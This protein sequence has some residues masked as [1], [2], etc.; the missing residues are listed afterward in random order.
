MPGKVYCFN[1]Y[2]EPMI[3]SVNGM[4]AGTISG[5][6]ASGATIYTPVSVAVDRARHGDHQSKPVFADDT[7]TP[8]VLDWD[9]FTAKPS[10]ATGAWPSISLDDDLILYMAANQ[11]S[12]MTTRGF[13]LTTVPYTIVAKTPNGVKIL[14]SMANPVFHDHKHKK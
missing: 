3:F 12:L 2:N 7:T 4:S 6:S 1:C 11:M 8:L 14:E 5:W 9:T 13:V 10:I